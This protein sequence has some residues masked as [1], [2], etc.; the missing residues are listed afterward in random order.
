MLYQKSQITILPP[1][2]QSL[3]NAV[4]YYLTHEYDQYQSITPPPLP[5]KIQGRKLQRTNLPRTTRVTNAD[6][7]YLTLH[8]DPLRSSPVNY[9]PP[10]GGGNRCTS[11]G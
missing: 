9:A 1:M 2:R 10:A 11:Y 4:T 8:Y 7:Y 6:T 5:F 3:T